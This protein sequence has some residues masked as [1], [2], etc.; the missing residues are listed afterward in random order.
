MVISCLNP[1]VKGE[2]STLILLVHT[3]QALVFALSSFV[4]RRRESR[5]DP[6]AN[7]TSSVFDLAC[8]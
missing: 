2:V 5:L 4:V 6:R 8:M 1:E 3:E 7:A